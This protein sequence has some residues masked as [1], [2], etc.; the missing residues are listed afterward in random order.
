VGVAAG[1]SQARVT[2]NCPML[3][4][5]VMRRLITTPLSIVCP[6]LTH[7]DLVACKLSDVSLRQC[8]VSAPL[9]TR[10]SLAG[11]HQLT[12]DT[13]RHVAASCPQLTTLNVSHCPLLTIPDN[14]E[15]RNLKQL[16]MVRSHASL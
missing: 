6:L 8:A 16:W 7:L 4:R 11:C 2:V 14:F 9:L 12:D 13:L 1:W 15:P 5:L 10:L 3:Q